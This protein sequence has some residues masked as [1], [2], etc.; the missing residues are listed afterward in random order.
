MKTKTTE[1]RQN[2]TTY[3]R[4]KEQLERRKKRLN[5]RLK[6]TGEFSKKIVLQ[7]EKLDSKA[8]WFFFSKILEKLLFFY[9]TKGNFM[10]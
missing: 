3:V 9:G 5:Y 6:L 7:T 10:W 4:V 1:A 8:Q 2:F